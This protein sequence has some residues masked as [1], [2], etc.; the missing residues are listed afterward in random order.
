L[1]KSVVS[2]NVFGRQVEDIATA[3][4]QFENGACASLTVSHTSIEPQDTLDIYA[5]N[6]SIHIPVL[7]KG[8]MVVKIGNNERLESHPPADNL[9]APL[10]EDFVDSVLHD[11][12]PAVNGEIGRQ[13]SSM[14]GEIYA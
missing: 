3:L 8:E 5:T 12:E 7:N 1:I 14:V 9:H 2:N 11:R 4:L 13:I 10:I 6:G